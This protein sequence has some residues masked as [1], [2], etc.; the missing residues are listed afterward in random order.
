MIDVDAVRKKEIT[1]TAYMMLKFLGFQRFPVQLEALS[2]ACTDRLHIPV[3]T[4]SQYAAFRKTS[5]FEVAQQLNS[6][7]AVTRFHPAPLILYNDGYSQMAHR[8]RFSLAHEVGH[9]SLMH[10]QKKGAYLCKGLPVPKELSTTLETEANYF[11]ANFLAPGEIVLS[12]A[13]LYSKCSKYSI[14]GL[15]REAFGLGKEAAYIRLEQLQ[16]PC[17]RGLL[18]WERTRDYKPYLKDFGA[19]YDQDFVD[20]LTDKHRAD[21][22]QMRKMHYMKDNGTFTPPPVPWLRTR[23]V[24][25]D[26]MAQ[27]STGVG[28]TL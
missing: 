11:A 3:C 16:D 8:Q 10:N 9:V 19:L 27:I 15:L 12:V 1:K 21:Y 24:V 28:G 13:L 17:G 25:Q 22:E 18:S 7:E 6:F 20:A 23:Q 14:Y 26:V 2:Q 5:I 4:Y